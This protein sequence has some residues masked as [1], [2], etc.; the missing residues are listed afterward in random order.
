MKRFVVLLLLSMTWVSTARTMPSSASGPVRRAP[1]LK[2]EKALIESGAGASHAQARAR[3]HRNSNP[4]PTSIGFLTA[5]PAA[6]GGQTFSRPVAGDFN[7][8]SKPDVAVI[9][10]SDQGVT[11]SLAVLLGNGD[12]TFQAAQLA[13][14]TYSF[15]DRIVAGDL[16]GDGNTD[17]VLLHSGSSTNQSF[18]V[19]LSNGDGTFQPPVNYSDGFT[20]PAAILIQDVAGDAKPDI[21]I[22]DGY[23]PPDGPPLPLVS[24]FT[25]Q[26]DGSFGPPT[27]VS[28]PSPVPAAI[29][30]DVNG[31]GRL[32]IVSP[33]GVYL[34]TIAGGY[35]APTFLTP[36]GGQL[37]SCGGVD[38]SFVVSD[39][40]G[41]GFPE[42]A[43]ADCSDNTVTVYVNHGDGTYAQGVAYWAGFYPQDLEVQNLAGNSTPDLLAANSQ[44]SDITA[45]INAGDGTFPNAQ[46]TGYSSGGFPW[47]QPL[48]ADFNGDGKID[49][50]VS[51]FSTDTSLTLMYMRGFG[52]GTFVAARDYFSPP[53]AGNGF[54]V[55]VASADFNGDGHADFV[56]GNLGSP[57][58]GITVFL[59]DASGAL[60]PGVNLGTNGSMAFVGTGDFN[61]DGHADIVASDLSSG[62]VHLFTGDG[63]GGFTP[64]LDVPAGVN[65]AYDMAVGDIDGVNGLDVALVDGGSNVEILLNDGSGGL[66]VAHTYALNSPGNEIKAADLTNDGKLDLVIPQFG[67]SLVS[68]LKGNGDG[69]FTALP[70]FDLGSNNPVNLAIGD[71]DHDGNADLAVTIDDGAGM[72]IAVARGKGDGTFNAAVLYPATSGS[73][74][75]FP[76]GIQMTD[77]NQDGKLDLVYE[78]SQP[79]TV[80]ILFGKGDGTF[81]DPVEYAAGGYP[82]GM[83]AAQANA[84]SAPD[85]VLADDEYPGITVLLNQ[86]GNLTTL[87][88]SANP[89]Q[90][91]SS[92]T[93]TASVAATVAGVTRTP[94]GTVT[95]L[96]GA[97]SLGS[98]T[99]SGGHATLTT[100]VLT[101]G[102]HAITA[103]YGGDLRFV[104]SV[105]TVLSQ[106]VN[107]SAKPSF[108]LSAAPG[109]ATLQKGQS[110]SFTITVTPSN[111]YNGTVSFACSAPPAGLSCKFTPASVTPSNGPV[112]A[113]LKVSLASDSAALVPP[114]GATMLLASLSFGL[115]GMLVVGGTEKGRR[116]MAACVAVML[117]LGILSLSGCGLGNSSNQSKQTKQTL[118]IV[119]QGTAGT[120]GGGSQSQTVN[121]TIT[122]QK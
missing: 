2:R 22:A 111:G 65:G 70:D 68:V 36:P 71:L 107:S 91:G 32:D 35:D 76:S 62:D 72:G 59:T 23:P 21:V 117:F 66:T 74:Q 88:S 28:Y 10:S 96:D 105:S 30:A 31:D 93:L 81:Y 38:G 6:V 121:L 100:S 50:L 52:D 97:S 118:Q 33:A 55:S 5:T 63:A 48:L 119:G 58:I 51:N 98:G 41:D 110:A 15:A 19:F 56:A 116:F 85:V 122:V 13:P 54:S 53:S 7:H 115:F 16:N 44:S 8:D 86:G 102:T 57:A 67:S 61:R 39:L 43:T 73:G 82:Y 12:G 99:L 108:A 26:G 106:V 104:P 120:G 75:P 47:M 83:V 18:D 77:V 14:A 92:V 34:A 3:F 64:A 84:D 40:N 27:S 29:L 89:S 45:L 4:A 69:S 25:N 37:S 20:N 80:G 11:F 87:A 42:I 9:V 24:T 90:Q 78:N 109:S 113:Q 95:F 94:S 17:I 114:Q 79:A 103:R 49:A 46:T 112:Q 1:M 101:P 60:R